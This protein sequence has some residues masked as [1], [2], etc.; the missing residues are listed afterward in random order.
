MKVYV[1]RDAAA[2][3]LGADAVARAIAAEAEA[4]G[5]AMQL[6]R[7]GSRGMLWL[8][9]LVEVETPDGRV[10]YGPMTTADVHDLFEAGFLHGGAH[11]LRLGRV[12]EIAWFARQQRLCFARV[13][14]VDPLDV[15]D[16]LAHGGYAGLRNALAMAPA[17]ELQRFSVPRILAED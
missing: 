9:P 4:H 2:L 15:E 8:E 14:V 13:G 11:A 16:H 17:S 7:N 10:A 1:P 3:S 6:V 12:E 5:T